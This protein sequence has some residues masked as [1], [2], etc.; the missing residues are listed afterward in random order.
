MSFGIDIEIVAAL[1][2]AVA[3]AI[4][5]ASA[6]WSQKHGSTEILD[7]KLSHIEKRLKELKTYLEAQESIEKTNRWS[8]GFLTV[9]QYIVGGVLA[10]SFIQETL[11]GQII[12]FLG[13]L[14]L[15]SQ[16]VHQ[17]FRPDLRAASARSRVVRLKRMLRSAHDQ[18]DRVRIEHFEE[19]P[20]R[21]IA[22]N[23]IASLISA[24]I[25]EVEETEQQELNNSES[26]QYK[27]NGD[28]S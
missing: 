26:I 27:D 5:A 12:G 9:G 22:E 14:V 13:V 6:S 3:T 23:K 4:G 21:L 25:S 7:T 2:S 16:I 17:R 20:E 24:Q 10:T 28:K 1:A 19:S 11:S 8:G 15:V 18:I